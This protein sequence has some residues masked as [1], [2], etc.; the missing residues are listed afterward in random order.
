MLTD[1]SYMPVIDSN[2]KVQGVITVINDVSKVAELQAELERR[3]KEFEGLNDKFQ[4]VYTQLK[5][6]DRAKIAETDDLVQIKNDMEQRSQ[7]MQHIDS[8]LEKKKRELESLSISIESK[9]GELSNINKELEENRSALGSAQTELEKKQ[10]EIEINEKIME[11]PDKPLGGKLILTDEIN[12][13][14][15][16]VDGELKTKKIEESDTEDD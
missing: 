8:I 4:E 2:E 7:E 13:T 5:L 6:A 15:N 12:K 11:I 14:L 9:T 1:L 10:K 16:V 3:Q